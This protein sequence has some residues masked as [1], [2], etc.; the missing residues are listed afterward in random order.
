MICNFEEKLEE[1]KL[2]HK[3]Y[4]KVR[5]L[6]PRQFAELYEQNLRGVATFDELVDQIFPVDM[7]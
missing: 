3:R 7:T 6:N 5:K 4:E 1:L 2:A